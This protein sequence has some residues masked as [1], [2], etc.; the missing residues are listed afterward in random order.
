MMSHLNVHSCSTDFKESLESR[1]DSAR[2]AMRQIPVAL[3]SS[4]S[5][6]LSLSTMAPS[7]LFTGKPLGPCAPVCAQKNV[8]FRSRASPVTARLET[9]QKSGHT[10]EEAKQGD[11]F[12]EL[13]ELSKRQSVNRPQDVSC[14]SKTCSWAHPGMHI[15]H[16]AILG[17]SKLS[18]H[19]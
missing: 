11:A 8:G 16:F 9:P 19:R 10:H 17:R 18:N 2:A 4:A 1:H 3:G 12:K 13:V 5:E 6:K 7:T 15:W 14:L